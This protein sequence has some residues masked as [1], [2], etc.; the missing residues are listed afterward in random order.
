MATSSPLNHSPVQ[1]LIQAQGIQVRFGDFTALAAFDLLLAP[2][3]VCALI[4]PNGAGKS[5][6][7]KALAGLEAES[8]GKL[9]VH[10][11]RPKAAP[12]SWKRLVGLLPEHLSLFD[13]LSV[14]EHLVLS[15]DLYG[16]PRTE[17]RRRADELL[18][19]LGLQEG[20]SRYAAAASYGMRKKTALALALLHAP[21][22]LLLDEP[23][24]GLDPASCEN[25]L[26]LL[27]RA[28]DRGVGIVVSS[29]M[30]MHVERLATQVLLLDRGRVAWRGQSLAQGDLHARYLEL[31]TAAP[32]PPLA[33]L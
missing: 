9:L 19:L 1:Y 23:F 13:A 22:L 7:L 12:P 5:T 10:G 21:P 14:E 17:T 15:G 16:L 6:A 28:R 33:W 26:A 25:V 30:L 2:G 18:S 3:E 11:Q 27:C 20:K 32:L 24:E 8:G 29:H 4:G 31:I